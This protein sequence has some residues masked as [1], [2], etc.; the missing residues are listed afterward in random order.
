MRAHAR[1]GAV[2]VAAM[3]AL[4]GCSAQATSTNTVTATGRTLSIYLSAPADLAS[5]PVARDVIDAEDLAFKQQASTA[6]TRYKLR[7]VL[8]EKPKLSDNAR[9]AIQDV[10]TVAYLGEIAPGDSEQ[11]LGIT[12]ALDI[13]QVSPTDTALEET[14]SSPAISGTP[15]R[16]Y[17]SASVYGRTY[18]QIAP[19]SAEEAIA[20]AAQMRALHVSSVYVGNDGSDYGRALARAVQSAAGKAGLPVASSLTGAGAFFFAS[21]SPSLA[22]QRFASAAAAS[23]GLEEFGPS[24]LATPGFASAVGSGARNVYVSVPAPAS[25]SASAYQSFASAFRSAYNHAPDAQAVFGYE[26]MSV[27]LS[28]LHEAGQAADSRAILVK[29]LHRVHDRS[30]ALGTYSIEKN[31]SS[32]LSSFAFDRVRGGSLVPVKPT[33]G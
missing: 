1:T 16:Y 13:P 5:N 23:P 4:A 10:S 18:V 22:A 28:V 6:V 26:A 21:A 11:T 30:S 17:E 31:G 29:D 15:T 12:N 8:V 2:C 19:S 7:L 20:Q 24:A 14:Q 33:R 3:A 32:S 9:A 27:V 25:T